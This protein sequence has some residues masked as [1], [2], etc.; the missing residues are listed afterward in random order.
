MFFH[1]APP[2]ASLSSVGLA[3]FSVITN[4][5]PQ[6]LAASKE[7][8]L[9]ESMVSRLPSPKPLGSLEV[10]IQ[11][12]LSWEMVYSSYERTLEDLEVPGCYFR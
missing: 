1:P 6:P 8:W 12:R 9:A 2:E 11:K 4:C 3:C 7:P 5:V 10:E